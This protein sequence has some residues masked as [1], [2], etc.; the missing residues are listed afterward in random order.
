MVGE[1]RNPNSRGGRHS[2]TISI[3]TNFKVR[4][5]HRQKRCIIAHMNDEQS[6]RS[7]V[8][9]EGVISNNTPS[10]QQEV[11]TSLAG[12]P[13]TYLDQCL[14][15]YV[16]RLLHNSLNRNRFKKKLCRN[17]KCYSVLCAS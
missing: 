7:V 15:N 16:G 14:V 13:R 11:V 2:G 17:S 1:Q 8:V 5:P 6:M 3:A 12:Q 4:R 9:T 10:G